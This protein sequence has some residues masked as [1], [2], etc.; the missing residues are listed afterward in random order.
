MRERSPQEDPGDA[1]CDALIA[2]CGSLSPGAVWPGE[3]LALCGSW[4]RLTELARRHGL[5]PALCPSGELPAAAIP[6]DL[7]VS[8]KRRRQAQFAKSACAVNQLEEIAAAFAEAGTPFIALKGAAAILW[9][10]EE[11]ECREVG[12]L[13]LLV[14]P[15]AMESARQTMA[16]LGYATISAS[17]SP[18]DER[19]QMHL[20]S[21]E[22]PG[23]LPVQLHRRI[24][25]GRDRQG[26]VTRAVWEGTVTESLGSASVRRLSWPHFLLHTAAHF[27]VHLRAD[28]ASLKGMADMILAVRKWG[29]PINWGNF[30][31]TAAQWGILRDVATAASTLNHHWGLSIPGVPP[32]ARPLPAGVLVFGG[33][34]VGSA[35]LEHYWNRLAAA[36]ELPGLSSRIRY[37]LR[38]LFPTPEHLRWRYHVPEGKTIAP[39]YFLYPFA[40]VGRLAKDFAAVI[41]PT[42]RG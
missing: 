14:P 38:L 20:P 30:W 7:L 22:K 9:L 2:L 19:V 21:Y 34:Q 25:A 6:A 23:C 15:A 40:R 26:R 18:E 8:W 35:S 10:Y 27:T 37:V 24:L 29:D 41:R 17:T 33:E 31:R 13:D 11:I 12:D 42:R 39:Y 1:L 16:G 5:A 4:L 28:S 3:R 32:G 36:Q